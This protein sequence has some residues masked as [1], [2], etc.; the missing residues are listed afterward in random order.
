MLQTRPIPGTDLNLSAIAF[1]TA[2]WKTLPGD[3][4]DELYGIFRS[5]GGNCFDTAH[6]YAF[7]RDAEGTPERELGRLIRA[8]GDRD[9][10]IVC[11]KGCHISGGEKYPRPERY[12]TPE[13]LASDLRDSL[14]R[15]QM[16]YVDL[17]FLHRDDPAVGVDEIMDA[18]HAHQQAGRIRHYAASNWRTSRLEQAADYCRAKGMAPFVASQVLYNLGQ[19][20][21]PL[22]VDMVVLE[23]DQESWYEK[24]GLPVFAYAA[25]AN[26]YF[27]GDS[28]EGSYACEVSATRRQRAQKLA[29]EQKVTPGQIALAYIMNQPFPVIP[30]IGTLKIAHLQDNLAAAKIRLTTEQLRYLRG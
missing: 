14:E 15:L 13:A 16:D 25:T 1:G 29:E 24:H 20:A 27:A 28:S 8:H 4:L 17:Y 26:G 5:A 11:T 10:V 23:K 6:C 3:D 18:L 19:L 30:I 7:W 9:N 12:M 21:K 2:D 22:G